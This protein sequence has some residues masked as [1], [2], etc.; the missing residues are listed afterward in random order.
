MV[1]FA[2]RFARLL[3]FQEYNSPKTIPR[4]KA[5]EKKIHIG[6]GS[7]WR[8]EYKIITVIYCLRF[9]A[10][11]RKEERKKERKKAREK[12]RKRE[13]RKEKAYKS[14]SSFAL[15]NEE[16][17]PVDVRRCRFMASVPV[18]PAP[19]PARPLGDNLV[20]VKMFPVVD[21]RG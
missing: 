19:R 15:R 3:L 14:E 17:K 21:A 8:L 20:A 7:A 2:S 4:R 12:E 9:K 6:A 5:T 16:D 18:V 13:R 11:R 1:R 10:R